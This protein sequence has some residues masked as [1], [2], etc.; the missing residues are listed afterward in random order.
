MSWPSPAPPHPGLGS[1]DVPRVGVQ[2]PGALLGLHANGVLPA[3]P[4]PDGVHGVRNAVLRTAAGTVLYADDVES[5]VADG[6]GDYHVHDVA[7]AGILAYQD[8]VQGLQPVVGHQ[9][10][11]GA[12]GLPVGDLGGLHPERID[13]D[14]GL[15]V[16]ALPVGRRHRP[17]HPL[18]TEHVAVRTDGDGYLVPRCVV[19][20]QGQRGQGRRDVGIELNTVVIPGQYHPAH[21]LRRRELLED[22]LYDVVFES[23]P[24]H[25]IH[26]IQ[27]YRPT[28]FFGVFLEVHPSGPPVLGE[29]LVQR[30]LVDVDGAHPLALLLDLLPG[31]VV[32]PALPESRG[33]VVVA[34][35][36]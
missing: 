35:P 12:D 3:V 5:P 25:R 1:G 34:S 22:I 18:G 26:G 13:R 21:L 30:F 6:P 33:H 24:A 14:A 27:P 10:G 8:D 28:D 31:L 32:V 2:E 19:A 23:V 11:G 15:L 9:F 17:L 20:L 16:H 36:D 4:G 7:R 29:R